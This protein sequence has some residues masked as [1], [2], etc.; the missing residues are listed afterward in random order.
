MTRQE[1]IKLVDRRVKRIVGLSV[2]CLPDTYELCCLYDTCEE[3][4]TEKE[5]L[6]EIEDT[7]TME[8]LEETSF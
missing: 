2:H 5:I 8:F 3:L 6:S 7:I 1:I 4:E